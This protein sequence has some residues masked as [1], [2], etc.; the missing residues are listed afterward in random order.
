MKDNSSQ[1][2][3]KYLYY[4]GC[5]LKGTGKAYET[6]LL[7]V[8]RALEVELQELADWNCCGAT[9]YMSVDEIKAFALAGR[10]LALAEA[11]HQDADLIAPCSAC[12]LVLNKAQRYMREYRDIGSQVNGALGVIGME[13]RGTVRIR[14]PL[15]VLVNDIGLE[16]IAPKITSPLKG[17]KVAPYY[18]CQIV[19]PYST[20]DD[21]HNPVTMDKL[22]AAAG[23]EV[24]DYPF[25]T[26]CCGGSLTGTMPDVGVALVH[27]LLKEA[28]NR[29][30]DL[31][32]TACPLC[33]FNLDGYQDKA[34]RMY[35]REAV[36][37]PVVY[38][39]QLLGLALGIPAKELDLH[40]S[41][42]P[43]APIL[44]ERGVAYV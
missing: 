26:R 3:R 36:S 12:Y 24:V 37:M 5:S 22:L 18:G 39:T 29:D 25:K 35:E 7:A 9:A 1:A 28:S 10:N 19:R 13:Y 34:K 14:H 8:F 27:A 17:L 6:S 11:D 21:R 44:A 15:D 30:A 38:F 4:P 43:A 16:A 2:H 40:R 41:I 23:A 31:I 20:F 32:A 42:V 33:Q